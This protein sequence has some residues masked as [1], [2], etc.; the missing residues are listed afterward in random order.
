MYHTS[1]IFMEYKHIIYVIK[2]QLC[3][4]PLKG[5]ATR[6]EVILGK[7][8]SPSLG[9]AMGH[10]MEIHGR[11]TFRWRSSLVQGA[12]GDKRL[13]TRPMASTKLSR[14]LLEPTP[15]PGACRLQKTLCQWDL[16]KKR[17]KKQHRD[18]HAKKQTY[19]EVAGLRY[20]R[21]SAN[22]HPF[23]S[24]ASTKSCRGR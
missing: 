4:I 23:S 6:N 3:W 22:H 11:T 17:K 20:A 9:V 5:C 19:G 16:S 10:P 15:G 24:A 21:Q 1:Q 13:K 8:Q 7:S 12:K 14:A 2:A 18:H